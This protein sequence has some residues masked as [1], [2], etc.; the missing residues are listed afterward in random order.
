M[1]IYGRVSYFCM[2]LRLSKASAVICGLSSYL[3]LLTMLG[4][5]DSSRSL[6]DLM[7]FKCYFSRDV[8]G[9]PTV[10]LRSVARLFLWS[11][12]SCDAFGER[13]LERSVSSDS[14]NKWLV[15]ITLHHGFDWITRWLNQSELLLVLSL[16]VGI[17]IVSIIT[18]L[19]TVSVSCVF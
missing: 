15:W 7:V 5:N 11:T 9:R 14:L 17:F 18:D 12:F 16:D 3:H 19:W 4:L 10:A 1:L 13:G 2:G 8:F 6:A